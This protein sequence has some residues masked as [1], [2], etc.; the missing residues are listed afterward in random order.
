MVLIMFSSHLW[1]AKYLMLI[2]SL[3]LF[4]NPVRKVDVKLCFPL[5]KGCES[6]AQT[7][8]DCLGHIRGK[9]GERDLSF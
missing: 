5:S 4:M 9:L 1:L 6:E 2:N 8:T 3:I 7:C